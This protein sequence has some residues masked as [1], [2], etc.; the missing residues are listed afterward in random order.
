MHGVT[1]GG[2]A[3]ARIIIV[4]AMGLALAMMMMYDGLMDGFNNAIYGNAIRV[5]GGNIQVHASGLPRKS[6]K[7]PAPP[8]GERQGRGAGRLAA[9]RM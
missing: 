7:Q 4:A 6:G 2:T 9:T 8:I 3:A 5:L 1:S